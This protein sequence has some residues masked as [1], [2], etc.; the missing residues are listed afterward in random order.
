[1]YGFACLFSRRPFRREPPLHDKHN[2]QILRDCPP[3]ELRDGPCLEEPIE[4]IM[5]SRLLSSLSMSENARLQ[6]SIFSGDH[7]CRD[8]GQGYCEMVLVPLCEELCPASERHR[9]VIEKNVRRS[10]GATYS[11]QLAASL[12]S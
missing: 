4:P 5:E 1:M 10:L 9:R 6:N 11:F 2:R 3:Y 8:S 7:E 12:D